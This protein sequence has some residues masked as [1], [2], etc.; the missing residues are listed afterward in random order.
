MPK[1]TQSVPSLAISSYTA[2]IYCPTP[3]P[4]APRPTVPAASPPSPSSSMAVVFSDLHAESG[5]KHLDEHLSGKTYISG[6]S[7][8]KDD[9]KVFA[10]V[11][12]VPGGDFRNA[13]KCF[14]GKAAVVRIGG[15]SPAAEVVPA[16]K[17][18]VGNLL[19]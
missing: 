17:S 13:S 12:S 2:L 1:P 9:V 8:T 6:E 3:P 18:E 5:L 11:P 15:G 14:P 16:G 10:A 19:F 7:L 4:P